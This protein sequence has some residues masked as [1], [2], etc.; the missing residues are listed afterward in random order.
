MYCVQLHERSTSTHV[1]CEYES[2]YKEGLSF[3]CCLFFFSLS[4]NL[5]FILRIYCLP[6]SSQR[7]LVERSP[8]LLPLSRLVL[9][10]VLCPLPVLGPRS[11][12]LT[13]ALVFLQFLQF[14]LFLPVDVC[15]SGVQPSARVGKLLSSCLPATPRLG[16]LASAS[17]TRL[18]ARSIVCRGSV[19]GVRY[20]RSVRFLSPAFARLTS[21]SPRHLSKWSHVLVPAAL[22]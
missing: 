14:L 13:I 3:S 6:I 12:V 21:L 19:C 5:L 11:S 18:P 16:S 20:S 9:S 22:V 1:S 15:S 17:L 8:V 7:S 10:A 2:V 4:C